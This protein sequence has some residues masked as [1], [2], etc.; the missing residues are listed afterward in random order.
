MAG[1][2]TTRAA[3]EREHRRIMRDLRQ[4]GQAALT[5]GL[6]NPATESAI[7]GMGI[8]LRDKLQDATDPTRATAAAILRVAFMGFLL[9]WRPLVAWG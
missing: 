4:Q 5:W 1:P 3:E 8:V 7:V 9:F 2:R 6:P